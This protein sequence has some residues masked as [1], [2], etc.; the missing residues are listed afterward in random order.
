MNKEDF[1]A[2]LK[3]LR[4]EHEAQTQEEA[5]RLRQYLL[6]T[7]HLTNI[8]E[9]RRR[10]REQFQATEYTA[11]GTIPNLMVQ[12]NHQQS[13]AELDERFID[14]CQLGRYYPLED[15]QYP[16]YYCTTAE[17]FYRQRLNLFQLSQ[18]QFA[19]KLKEMVDEAEEMAKQSAG[20]AGI[21]GEDIPG[22]GCYL[23]GWLFG[24]KYQRDPQECWQDE[25][26]RTE[27]LSTAVHEK[28][29][30]GFLR[31]YS[32][33]GREVKRLG[34][35]RYKLAQQ[36]GVRF[37]DDPLF[38]L[39]VEQYNLI[40]SVSQLLE[41]GWATWIQNLFQFFSQPENFPPPRFTIEDLL[42]AV[43]RFAPLALFDQ[44]E[45]LLA[46]IDFLFS[47]EVHGSGE[48]YL[49][50]L[51]SALDIL[52]SAGIHVPSSRMATT[53]PLVYAL[54]ELLFHKAATRMGVTLM[55]YL[56]LLAGNV[57]PQLE[58]LSLSDLTYFLKHG[59]PRLNPNTRLIALCN[60]PLEADGFA[61]LD[62]LAMAAL[63]QYGF[64]SPKEWKA[65]K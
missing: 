2:K 64:A 39:R 5:Q 29:G 22:Q 45:I 20:Q 63:E 19:Q 36:A 48:E 15:I 10:L 40:F 17:E 30:H 53:Q 33:I 24:R 43:D 55:P 52:L 51:R 12:V 34:L 56:A 49:S 65:P 37:S 14:W 61:N 31:N 8:E 27:I 44:R 3:Q 38:N 59:D 47:E 42:E 35:L 25:Q 7:H 62:H 23:N 58:Q 21:F 4:Q 60:L 57:N 11:T 6:D 16:T 13:L 18:A 46:A 50:Q 41:E 26:S 28:L 54:G 32:T 9:M 1:E